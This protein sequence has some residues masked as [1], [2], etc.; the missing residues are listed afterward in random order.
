MA[1]LY[2]GQEHAALDWHG[3][4][5]HGH[6]ARCLLLRAEHTEPTVMAEITFKINVNYLVLTTSLLS[7]GGS[8]GGCLVVVKAASL[9]A[10]PS[11]A[12]VPAAAQAVALTA[13]LVI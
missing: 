4:G 2:S 5:H 1:W 9:G 8:S 12:L 10:D 7:S 13:S 3:Q 11:P 6:L